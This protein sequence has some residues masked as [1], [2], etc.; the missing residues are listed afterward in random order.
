LLSAL[1]EKVLSVVWDSFS[2]FEY[3]QVAVS[4]VNFHLFG[5]ILV[6]TLEADFCLSD[7]TVVGLAG[8]WDAEYAGRTH[9]RNSKQIG[10]GQIL[11]MT[12]VILIFH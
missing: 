1:P 5:S 10:G 4:F 12:A 8:I 9:C 7:I 3:V 6:L 2:D 11:N